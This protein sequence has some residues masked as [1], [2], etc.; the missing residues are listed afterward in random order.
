MNPMERADHAPEEFA[1]YLAEQRA[2]MSARCVRPRA[3]GVK[4]GTG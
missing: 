4:D 2:Q 1:R 3:S